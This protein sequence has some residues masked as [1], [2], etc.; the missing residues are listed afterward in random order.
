MNGFSPTRLIREQAGA[1]ASVRVVMVGEIDH[2][3]STL[4]GRLLHDTG[5]LPDEKLKTLTAASDGR[6]MGFEWAFLIDALQTERDQGITLDT[7]QI[8]L[9]TPARDVIL[10]DAPGHA[11]FLR[12]MITGAAQ[13]DAALLVI[14]ATEG[15]REQTRRHAYLLYLLGIRQVAVV[16]NKMDRFDFDRARFEAIAVEITHRLASFGLCASAIVPVSARNG[17]GVAVRTPALAW[18]A[19]PT[20]LE[21]LDQFSSAKPDDELALRIPVQAVYKFD[22]R[23]IVAGRIESGRVS[24]GDEITIAPRGTKARV[25]SIEAWPAAN[26]ARAPR[27]AGAGESIGLILDRSLFVARGDLLTAGVPA[28]AVR[29][30]WARIFWLNAQPLAPGDA[31]GLRVGTARCRGTIEAIDN[32]VDPGLL[33]PDASNV[34]APNHVGEVEIA[35]EQ[36]LAAD[37]HAENLRTGRVVLDVADRIAGGGLILSIDEEA[38]A[39]SG[40]PAGRSDSF[41]ARSGATVSS[42]ADLAADAARL[43]GLLRDLPPGQRMARLAREIEGRTV[44]TTS[45]GLEDQVILHLIVEHGLDFEIVTLDTGRLFPETYDLWAKTERKYGRRVRALYP[46]QANLE[47][48][49]Q[50]FSIN[51]FYQSREARLACCRVR[52]AEPLGRALDGA[53][54]WVVGLRAGQSVNRNATRLIAVDERGLFKLSP[55]FDWTREAVQSFAND[56]GVPINP[57][58]ARSFVSIGCAPCTR[59]IAPGEPERAGRWWWEQDE[60]KECGLHARHSS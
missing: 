47:A 20:T 35:L 19:G 17:D 30:L 22:D 39:R 2:G 29:R 18:Y 51:G 54:A 58:H 41:S 50:R 44:F 48:M 5:N 42:S 53:A 40:T 43:D 37:I 52:K 1:R 16:I 11:E 10:I 34:I 7:S 6:G 4:I 24:V 56:N 3:K 45:F 49:V 15:V 12:N 31:V 57:L 32:A 13:A 36:P 8:R 14:D 59:A 46:Q 60:K 26:E 21:A 38:H 23:R 33:S 55:L 27:T 9:R 28:K 25:R